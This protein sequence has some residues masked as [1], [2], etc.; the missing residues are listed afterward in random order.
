VET[1]IVADVLLKVTENFAPSFGEFDVNAVRVVMPDDSGGFSGGLT[2]DI[3]F[4]EQDDVTGVVT[5]QEV[6]EAGAVNTAAYNCNTHVSG[7]GDMGHKSTPENEWEA[8]NSNE[9]LGP[10][11]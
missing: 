5:R 3:A 10:P 6:C 7:Y 4:L 1:A 11:E 8:A 9:W 2:S